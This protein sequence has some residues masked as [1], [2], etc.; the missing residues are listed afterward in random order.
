MLIGINQKS[1][2]L[3]KVIQ[4]Y[5]CLFLCFAYSSPIVFEGREGIEELNSLWAT[6]IANKIISGDLNEDGDFDD[7]GEAEIQSHDRLANLFKLNAYYDGIHHSSF[8]QVPEEVKFIFGKFVYK[9]GHFVVLDKNK[10]VI[11]DPLIYSNSVR[12]GKLQSM[13]YYYGI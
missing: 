9:F 3:L 2:G 8:E 1:K 13:R 12:Y 5:G 7:V 6:A 4:D 11:F 10:N